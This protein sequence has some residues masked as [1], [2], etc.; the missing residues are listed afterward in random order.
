MLWICVNKQKGGYQV[1]KSRLLPAQLSSYKF[2]SSITRGSLTQGLITGHCVA[3]PLSYTSMTEPNC[4]S[5][6]RPRGEHLKSAYD[7]H[8]KFPLE[9][10]SVTQPCRPFML[11]IVTNIF[12]TYIGHNRSKLSI[13]FL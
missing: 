6:P 7:S 1:W 2:K 3:L 12:I 8:K 4:I 10:V 9:R 13:A 11:S 5:L